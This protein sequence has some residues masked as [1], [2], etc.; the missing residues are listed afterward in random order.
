M[1]VDGTIDKFKARLVIQGFRQKEGIDYFDTYEPVARISTI[2]LLI[3]L[4]AT[5]NLVIDQMDVKTAF[6]NDDLGEEIYMKQ[7]EGFVMPGNEHKVCKLIKSLYGLK[8]APKQWHHKFDEVVLSN[9]FVLNQSDKCV[10][11]KFDES[12]KRVIIFL[13]VDDMLIFVIDQT[14]VDKTKEFLS[15]SFSMKDMG[16]A[17]VILGIRIKRE[18]KGIAITQSHYIEKN[19][20]KFNVKV[21]SQLVLHGSRFNIKCK[22]QE[23]SIS[24]LQVQE[25]KQAVECVSDEE[26]KRII[27]S[28][29]GFRQRIQEVLPA[30]SSFYYDTPLEQILPNGE[31]TVDS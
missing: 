8:Q 28:T 16:E 21:V 10:Y 9:G 26:I 31:E 14:Q 7:P 19:S 22:V 4:A 30:E 20:Q 15:S 6:L 2:R 25:M 29:Y 3:A 17:D 18:N 12:G 27:E 11:C 1:K 23:S 24:G 13:Y 5:H